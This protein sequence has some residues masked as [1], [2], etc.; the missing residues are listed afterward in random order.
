MPSDEVQDDSYQFLR[1]TLSPIT[2]YHFTIA[3]P[4]GW[5]TLDVIAESEPPPGGFAEIGVFRQPGPWME[6][7]FVEPMG[8]ISVSVVNMTGDA[9]WASV[10]M[11]DLLEKNLPGYELLERR[12]RETPNGTASDVLVRYNDGSQSIMNRLAAF[13]DGNTIYL[14]SGS[15]TVNGY[16]DNAEAYYVA[17]ASF[18]LTSKPATINPFYEE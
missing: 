9:R 6:N 16:R 8:E 10:W 14:V 18:V 5:Q 4:K 15:D 12:D 2:D 11:D 17:I 7:D 1:L 3:V 13:R